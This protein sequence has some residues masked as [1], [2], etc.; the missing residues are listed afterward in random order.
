MKFLIIPYIK[1]QKIG[2]HDTKYSDNDKINYSLTIKDISLTRM[3]FK[4]T[5]LIIPNLPNT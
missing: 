3:A 2:G 5:R 1:N 4:M